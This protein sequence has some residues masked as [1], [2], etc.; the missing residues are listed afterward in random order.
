MRACDKLRMHSSSKMRVLKEEECLEE[1]ILRVKKGRMFL[2]NLKIVSNNIPREWSFFYLFA[3]NYLVS[4]MN[5]NY[6][7]LERSEDVYFIRKKMLR[8]LNF[9]KTRTMHNGI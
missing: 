4:I 1:I 7:F 9:S 8:T 5:F 2:E 3:S 6:R